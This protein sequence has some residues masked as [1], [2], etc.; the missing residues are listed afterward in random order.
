[1]MHSSPLLVWAP[2]TQQSACCL[3][4]KTVLCTL[5]PCRPHTAGLHSCRAPAVIEAGPAV[6]VLAEY[7]L[8]PAEQS[9][10]SGRQSVMVA[11]REKHLLATAFH[12]ELTAD[13][14]W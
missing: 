14:R 11:V 9:A 1:M 5:L 10:A 3:Q 4:G 7:H 13:L 6:E 8:T 12:P 2:A